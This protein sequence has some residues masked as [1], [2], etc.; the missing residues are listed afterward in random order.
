MSD[1]KTCDK[2]N[3]YEGCVMGLAA[4]CGVRCDHYEPDERLYALRAR[5]EKAEADYRFM[6]ER[7]ADQKL[8]GY[9]ELGARAASAEERAE[10]AEAELA[11]LRE[12]IGARIRASDS[13]LGSMR[14]TLSTADLAALLEVRP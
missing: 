2:W 5:A 8:D 1:C 10:K 14:G 7:A 9:R 3:Q 6:V 11:R 13:C 12:G 4:A